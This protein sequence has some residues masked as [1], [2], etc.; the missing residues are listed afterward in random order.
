LRLPRAW[1]LRPITTPATPISSSI[2][3]AGSGTGLAPPDVEDEAEGMPWPPGLAEAG[4]RADL[5]PDGGE[6]L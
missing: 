6:A 3:S 5:L 2:A 4:G 1:S